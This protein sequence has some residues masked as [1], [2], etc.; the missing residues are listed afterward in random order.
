MRLGFRH[1]RRVRRVDQDDEVKIA[2]ADVAEQRRSDMRRLRDVARWSAAMHS[3]RREIGTHT[4]VASRA[5][6]GL[7]LQAREIGVVARLPQAAAVFRPGC[8]FEVRAAELGGNGLHGLRLLVDRRWRAVKFEKQRRRF[9]TRGLAEL[10]RW[11]A[12]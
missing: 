5:Q 10:V 2:V 8:P 4:S 1:L 9:A 11:P 7:Q 6:P 3:A 12:P